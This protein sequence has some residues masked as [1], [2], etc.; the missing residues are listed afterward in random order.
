MTFLCLFGAGG[1]NIVGRDSVY[2][3]VYH[4]KIPSGK[5][6]IHD[7]YMGKYTIVVIISNYSFSIRN[8]L[9]RPGPVGVT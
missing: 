3:F 7:V 6:I 4:C 9:H 1:R 2:H 8:D 5:R